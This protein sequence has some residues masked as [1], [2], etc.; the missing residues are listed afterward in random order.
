MKEL[1]RRICVIL[2]D[3]HNYNGFNFTPEHVINWASQFEKDDQQFILN[4]F[5][6][7]LNQ[8]IY[9][10]EQKTRRLL[11]SNLI[12]LAKLFKFRRMSD[13][14]N[15]ANFVQLQPAGKSQWFILNLLDNVLRENYPICLKE[16]GASSGKYT[17]YLDDILATGG[18]VYADAEKWLSIKDE[19]GKSNFQK[20]IAK[21]AIFI[22][23]VFAKH[24]WGSSNVRIRL[25]NKFGNPDLI[26]FHS[27]YDIENHPTYQNQ[28]MNFAYPVDSGIKEVKEYF[29]NLQAIYNGEY[30]YRKN[31]IPQ[32]EVFFSSPQNRIRFENIILIKGIK[33]LRKVV[34]L[35]VNQRPLGVTNPTKKPFGTGT[36][37]FSWRNISNT[38]PIVFW[39]KT[40]G[41]DWYPLFPLVNR[42]KN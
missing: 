23:S 14:L 22:V 40:S 36:L 20:V 31:K 8:G 13:F 39:W 27:N 1:A 4:E 19:T 25:N 42:G 12:E 11:L 32:E 6:H 35:Q 29:T 30:A 28:K 2:H 21:E 26:L 18:T 16:C 37:F 10:D 5:Y 38:S 9:I 15:N 41:S 33:Q 34:K 3:Y 7:L 24:I 17:V